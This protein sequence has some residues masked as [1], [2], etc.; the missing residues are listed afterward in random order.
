MIDMIFRKK[1]ETRN[2]M[3]LILLDSN[4]EIG[5]KE[6]LVHLTTKHYSDSQIAKIFDDRRTAINEV[7]THVK[8]DDVL[9]QKARH[10]YDRRNKLIH[11]RA[12]IQITDGELE[13]YRDVVEAILSKLFKL[14]FSGR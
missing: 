11:E 12:T 10:Y 5:L 14:D 1:H 13:D 7:K 4:F 3:A 2:R 6:Y 8:I 9:W